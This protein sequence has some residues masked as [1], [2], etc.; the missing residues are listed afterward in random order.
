MMAT[1]LQPLEMHMDMSEKN[2]ITKSD[3]LQTH[4]HQLQNDT[5]LDLHTSQ[6]IK[7][8][9]GIDQIMTDYLSNHI[10]LSQ[11]QLHKIQ[12]ILDQVQSTQVTTLI[13][14]I[15]SFAKTMCR[16]PLVQTGIHG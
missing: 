2:V 13:N 1:E 16:L 7:L 3:L 14:F 8:F 4:Q 15:F 12:Q 9:G 6:I 5:S 11:S 10:Q